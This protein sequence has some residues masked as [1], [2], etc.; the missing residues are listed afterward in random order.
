VAAAV[1]STLLDRFG[2]VQRALGQ[3]VRLAEVI[4]V[5]QGVRGVAYVDVDAFGAVPEKFTARGGVRQLMT[6][7]LIS[8]AVLDVLRVDQLR[9]T[10]RIPGLAPQLPTDVIA[11]PGGNDLGGLRPAELAIFT[12]A[13]PDTLILN[14]LS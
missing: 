8:Q 7:S 6:Q 1:R 10:R 3:S 4:S 2:F 13:V 12:P 14:P 5:I 9:K 11:F